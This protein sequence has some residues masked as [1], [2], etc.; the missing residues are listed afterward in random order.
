MA[1][2]IVYK[3]KYPKSY[4]Y[5]NIEQL[6]QSFSN[7]YREFLYE[8]KS[9]D[10]LWIGIERGDHAGYWYLAK[11]ED[12]VDGCMIKGHIEYDPENFTGEKS[13]NLYSKIAMWLM[14][15]FFVILFCIPLFI[16]WIIQ[17][18]RRPK[19]KKE[20]LDI[21]MVQYLECGKL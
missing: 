15:I 6:I 1:K 20:F 3:S 21:F 18:I 8:I 2:E 14:I 7:E 19:T 5:E 10:E 11:L 4:I 9:S 17:L 12:T 16:I 13:M